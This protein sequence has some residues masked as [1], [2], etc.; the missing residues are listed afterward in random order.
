[1]GAMLQSLRDL[2]DLELQIFDIREQIGRQERRVAA[3][4]AKLGKLRSELEAER[5][6]IRREQVRFDAL[7]L[8]LKSRSANIDKLREHLN[9]VRTNKEY[10]GFLAQMNNEKADLSKIEAQAMEA[11]QAVETRKAALAQRDKSEALE[12]ERLREAEQQLTQTRQSL[13]G[14]LSTLEQQRE[15]AI[16]HIDPKM[17]GMFRKLSERYNGEP[18]AAVVQPNPRLHEYLCSGCNMTL[19]PDVANALRVRD[20]LQT[21]KNCGKI[22][23]MER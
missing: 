15:D 6:H 4:Q 21:C 7:D 18:L 9:T 16:R 17:A 10:A 3:Q 1:M 5:E 19:R 23:F 2:Q 13:S 22:L 8:D 20:E 12:V 14:K 11:M